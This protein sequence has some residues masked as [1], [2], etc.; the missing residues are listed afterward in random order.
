MDCQLHD[1][2]VDTH[3]GAGLGPSDAGVKCGT[4]RVSLKFAYGLH[5]WPRER[6]GH[7]AQTRACPTLQALERTCLGQ[8]RHLALRLRTPKPQQRLGISCLLS[9]RLSTNSSS[10]AA[11]SC[12]SH[13]LHHLRRGSGHHKAALMAA[14]AAAAVGPASAPCC[15]PSSCQQRPQPEHCNGKRSGTAS[16]R[17]MRL[18][19]TAPTIRTREIHPIMMC[20]HLT[21]P[22]LLC[23]RNHAPFNCSGT[24]RLRRTSTTEHHRQHQVTVA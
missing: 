8:P 13:L 2:R 4:P 16:S 23:D 24:R 6:D 18:V 3:T 14:V 11:A 1:C 10:P 15:Y 22:R 5:A 20:A 21:Y 9:S 19:S 7:D 17:C 12:G